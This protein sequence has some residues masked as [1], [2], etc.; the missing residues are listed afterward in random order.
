MSSLGFVNYVTPASTQ[1]TLINDANGPILLFSV[2][3]TAAANNN[4][5]QRSMIRR[6]RISFSDFVFF[7]TSAMTLTRLNAPPSPY[8]SNYSL[9]GGSY[10]GP[11]TATRIGPVVFDSTATQRL[12]NYD[13]VFSGNGV[14]VSGSLVDGVY[15]LALNNAAIQAYVPLSPSPPYGSFPGLQ[16][17]G[18]VGSTTLTFHR[19]FGDVNGDR[20]VN[21]IDQNLAIYGF[22]A[23]YR[24]V[25]G[26]SKYQE[27]LDFDNDND[28]DGADRTQFNRRL[29][30]YT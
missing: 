9:T 4:W 20:V 30:L 12:F 23:A 25:R 15:D 22:N 2:T 5:Q 1:P 17:G 21:A 14:E 7:D 27:Y 11:V 29:N 6:A 26:Q 8:T 18:G 13:F 24:S 19:L 3:G 28:V 16:L 10:F